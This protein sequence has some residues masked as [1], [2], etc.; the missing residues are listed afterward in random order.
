MIIGK[1]SVFSG[2]SIIQWVVANIDGVNNVKDAE[3]LGQVLLDKGAIFHSD[4]S[5]SAH[6]IAWYYYHYIKMFLITVY[7]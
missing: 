6:H 1:G 5:R 3:Q 4:G 2:V 7:F